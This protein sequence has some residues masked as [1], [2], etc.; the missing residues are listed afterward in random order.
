MN[1]QVDN[2][3][4]SPVTLRR[5]LKAAGLDEEIAR[6]TK[7][8]L[9]RLRIDLARYERFLSFRRLFE[10]LERLAVTPIC[11]PARRRRRD[12]QIPKAA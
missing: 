4:L 6:A 5:K 9:P 8:S 2:A 10:Y 1:V 7:P 12:R 11:V 3:Q